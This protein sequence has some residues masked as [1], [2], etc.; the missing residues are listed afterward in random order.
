MPR[1]E[2]QRR[3]I[4]PT[5]QL[6]RWKTLAVVKMIDDRGLEVLHPS[7]HRHRRIHLHHS[8]PALIVCHPRRI[9]F[10]A[11]WAKAW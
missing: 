8:L 11:A 10:V 1:K 6:A 2:I 3:A 5:V 9:G 4:Q 7:P